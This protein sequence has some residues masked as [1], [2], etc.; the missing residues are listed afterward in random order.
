MIEWSALETSVLN[1]KAAPASR[2]DAKAALDPEVAPVISTST[3]E[4][5]SDTR[6]R[7]DEG[8]TLSRRERAIE[9]LSGD[10]T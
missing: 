2:A 10:P 9:D 6:R 4:S 8:N 1:Q 5:G 7:V 3:A